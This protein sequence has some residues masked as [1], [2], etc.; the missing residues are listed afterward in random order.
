MATKKIKNN[1]LLSWKKLSCLIFQ[2]DICGLDVVYST[3]FGWCIVK[4]SLDPQIFKSF[5]FLNFF[6][7]NIASKC[8]EANKFSN[9]IPSNNFQHQLHLP[10][11]LFLVFCSSRHKRTKTLSVSQLNKFNSVIID[12]EFSRN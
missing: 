9:L 2:A 5:E 3:D 6:L 7:K 8:N 11:N 12:R 10:I 4:L 1:F